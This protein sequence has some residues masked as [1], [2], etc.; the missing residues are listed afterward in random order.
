MKLHLLSSFRTHFRLRDEEINV[1]P[2]EYADFWKK[3]S[4]DVDEDAFSEIKFPHTIDSSDVERSRFRKVECD[5]LLRPL[6]VL[7]FY[8]NPENSIL[9][10]IWNRIEEEYSDKSTILS[11]MKLVLESTSLRL[12]NN[13]VALLQIDLDVSQALGGK[14]D[15]E[16]ATVLDAIQEIGIAFGEY[17]AQ[18]LYRQNVMPYLERIKVR[19]H[20]EA[21]RFIA[22]ENFSYKE[23]LNK[24]ILTPASTDEEATVK[25]NWVTRSLLFESCDKDAMNL[26]SI[27]E[28]WL[29]D[30]G[31]R[32]SIDEAKNGADVCVTRWLN[33]LFREDSYAW[34]T[35]K[36]GKVDY[37]LPFSDKWQAML[38]AQY[39]YAAFE[40]LNDTLKSTLSYAYQMKN[41]TE[42]QAIRALRSLNQALERDVVTANLTMLEYH[43]NYGYYNRQ[44]A[45]G[46]KEIMQGWDFDNA[47]LAQVERN[48]EL[49]K[50]RIDE[51]N[52]KALSRSS[53][54]SDSLLLGIAVT[55]IVAF[56]FQVIEYGRNVSLNADL[57]VYERNSFNLVESISEQPTDFI[58]LLSLL[59]IILL[60]SL[61]AWF[62]RATV[63]D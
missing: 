34:Q 21:S 39:Y 33:Y 30:C 55:S 53:F 20:R 15:E 11:G 36:H 24:A 37:G 56:L 25:V 23:A 12:H 18:S 62:R 45:L 4:H 46:M 22:T 59:L 3:V 10:T 27:V 41:R 8:V 7:E 29:K 28:H 57:S 17:L 14:S 51:L 43:N 54:Y 50:Q 6:H 60:F 49:C 13:S 42:R 44:V 47:I 61:Y 19:H 31:N 26:E 1:A 38:N 16:I 32:N 58:I 9:T 35:D 48:T 40:A 5:S 52:Q 63:M 2:G